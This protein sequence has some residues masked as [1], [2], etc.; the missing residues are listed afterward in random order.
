MEDATALVE[1]T[2]GA[3]QGDADPAPARC[4][5]GNVADRPHAGHPYCAMCMPYCD[6]FG[7]A[8]CRDCAAHFGGGPTPAG[9]GTPT[10]RKCACGTTDNG[11]RYCAGCGTFWP[12]TAAPP[13]SGRQPAG[14]AS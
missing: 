1:Q 9:E 8:G 4:C 3:V 10:P 5:C 12:A 6:Y 7:P 13:P 11:S 2:F 14:R